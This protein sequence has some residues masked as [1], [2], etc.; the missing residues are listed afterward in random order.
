VHHDVNRGRK[1]NLVSGEVPNFWQHAERH[2]E[3]VALVDERERPWSAGELLAAVNQVSNGLG[4]MN[5]EPGSVVATLMPKRAELIVVSLATSQIGLYLLTLN[6]QQSIGEIC[7]ALA[8]SRAQ[9]LI[10]DPRATSGEVMSEIKGAFEGTIIALG[11]FGGVQLYEELFARFPRSAPRSRSAGAIL[12]Y[13]SGT[14]GAPKAVLRQL[15]QDPP[16]SVYKSQIRWFMDTFAI[17]PRFGVHL[18]A[19]PLHYSGPLTFASYALHLG[20]TVALLSAWHPR[21]ALRWIEQ[22]RVTTAFMVPSQFVSLLK[23]PEE[24][25]MRYSTRSIE[26]VIHGSAP[27]PEAVKRAM[28]EWWGPILYE[29][30]GSTEVAGVVATPDD[31]L[32]FPGTVGRATRPREVRIYDEHGAAVPAGTVG[33]V[34]LRALPENEFTYLGDAGRTDACRRG[35][36]VTVGDVGCLNAAGYLFLHGRKGDAINCKGEKVF[37]AEV[38]AVLITHPAVLDCAVFGVRQAELGEEVRAAV[39]LA[40]GVMPSAELTFEL[41]SY[42]RAQ[43]TPG[44]CPRAIE[45]VDRIP[46]DEAGKLRRREVKGGY[47]T[48]PIRERS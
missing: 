46:R 33:N 31:W 20:H 12:T 24:Q 39:T 17:T 28:L 34:F 37:P 42:L 23:L 7:H 29:C 41:L 22:H 32:A 36:F 4:T 30:Y 8:D 45:Y 5:V 35:D 9:L 16:E 18:C 19:C 40:L 21:I 38:E 25:R 6:P 3:D 47:G 14:T 27:C 1:C 10:V 43:M 26:C 44:K 15:R 13:T 11:E 2:P 48:H